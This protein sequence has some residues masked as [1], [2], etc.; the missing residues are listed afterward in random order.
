[1]VVALDK[2]H[3]PM[4]FVTERRARK[5]LDA[6][7]ACVTKRYPFTICIKDV[8]KNDFKERRE[9]RIKVDPGSKET[10]I[11]VIDK[12]TNQVC[13]FIKIIHRGDLIKAA[14][15]TRFDARH[16][17]R[18]RETRYRRCKFGKGQKGKNH[19]KYQSS[20]PE[21]WLPPS[22]KSTADNIINW[23]K[24]LMDM[25]NAT[26]ISVESVKFDTQL[27]DNPNIEG[28]EYQHGE[29]FG[30]ELKEYLLEKYGHTCQ[31]CGG[32]SGDNILEWEHMISKANGGN[33]S[34]KNAALACRSCN[35]EKSSKNLDQWLD[36]LKSK[37]KKSELDEARIKCITDFLAG[38][39]LVRE[40]YAAWVNSTRK[41]LLKELSKLCHDIET[42]T[43]G[44]TKYNRTKLG[45]QK[46][47]HFDALCVVEVPED[48]YKNTNQ[49]VLVIK[50]MGRGS[51]LRGNINTC[52]IITTK[53]YDRHK[54]YVRT[55]DKTG[56]VCYFQSGDIVKAVIPNGK[57]TGTYIGRI[58]IRKSG[59]FAIKVSEDQAVNGKT[60][61]DVNCKYC[62]IIQRNDGYDY[63]YE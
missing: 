51:R 31:Y 33:N 21:G 16:N 49:K 52:G 27:M 30:Y 42:G 46:D 11:A 40:N 29:L 61:F 45:Y 24:R 41:Y 59:T 19:K 48:G 50:A 39:P 7:R 15:K 55:D 10:G 22:V 44:Q 20:R 35:T 60:K 37:P 26:S 43:G 6:K 47:H 54:C 1:M 12:K 53:Y 32:K 14:I 23:V 36:E 28:I 17:R 8:N 63:H 18:N 5:L 9:F 25:I 62:T 3:R 58:T 56:E 4:G 2:Y 34:V 13:L 57:Y 38:K